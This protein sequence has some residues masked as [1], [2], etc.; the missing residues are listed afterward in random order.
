MYSIIPFVAIACLLAPLKALPSPAEYDASPVYP[1]SAV[2]ER[3]PRVPV[4][5]GGGVPSCWTELSCS[6]HEIE[7]MSMSTRLSYVRYMESRFGALKS[8]SQFRAIEGVI[9]FFIDKGIG[10]PGTWVSY[11][12]AGIVE[13]IERG[14]AI[15]LG[16]GKSTGGNPG[17]AKWAAFLKNMKNGKLGNRNV[18]TFHLPNHDTIAGNTYPTSIP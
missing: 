2:L 10:G 5:G 15:A 7:S 3:S 18:S 8:S 14:G 12:D 16:I 11:V 13:A 4:D 6:F 1:V 17:S 9:Q